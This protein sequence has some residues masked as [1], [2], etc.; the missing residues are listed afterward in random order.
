MPESHY[1]FLILSWLV[2]FGLHS[3]L[4]SIAAKQDVASRWPRAMPAYRLGFNVLAV[5]LLALSP[6]SNFDP[7]FS[8]C[9]I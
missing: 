1:L 6:W 3:L 7:R 4:A 2:Y 8:C 9:S 5:L